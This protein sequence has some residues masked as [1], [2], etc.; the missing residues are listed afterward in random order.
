MFAAVVQPYVKN[1]QVGYCPEA[2]V[3]NW[4]SAI[5]ALAGVPYVAA[6]ETNGVYYASFAQMAVNIDLVEWNPSANWNSPN[7][8]SGPIG[9]IASWARPAETILIT[10]DSVWGD[11]TNGD[12]SPS[13]AVGNTGVWP[14][15]AGVICTNQGRPG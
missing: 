2:G 11:G 13:M 15:R 5:P 8:P 14:S 10:G 12:Q 1:L 3:T 7:P 4:K 9:A 6:L